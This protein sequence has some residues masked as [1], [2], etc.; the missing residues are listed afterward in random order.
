M[1]DM[2]FPLDLIWLDGDGRVLAILENVPPCDASPCPLYEP[3]GTSNSTAVLELPASAARVRGI[4]VGGRVR[5][6][7]DARHHPQ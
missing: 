6:L 2:R 5:S 1:A 7:A 3:E 4:V